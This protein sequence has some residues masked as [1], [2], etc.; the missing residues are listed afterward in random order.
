MNTKTSNEAILERFKKTYQNDEHFVLDAWLEEVGGEAWIKYQLNTDIADLDPEAQ[1][2]K[3]VEIP[4]EFEG[5]PT[6][7]TWWPRE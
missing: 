2:K 1:T 6:I 7:I 5:I 4:A 3:M